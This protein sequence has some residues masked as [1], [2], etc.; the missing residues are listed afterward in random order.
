MTTKIAKKVFI[1]SLVALLI[2]AMAFT[3]CKIKKKT[4]EEMLSCALTTSKAS[5]E[6][7]NSIVETAK[8]LKDGLVTVV[9]DGGE[10][11]ASMTLYYKDGKLA[12][13]TGFL[14]EL[15][16]IDL[17]EL[18]DK[19]PKSMFG[20]EGGNLFNFKKSDEQ[21]LIDAA[22]KFT[23]AEDVDIVKEI[24]DIVKENGTM[25]AEYGSKVELRSGDT[26]ADVL[27]LSFTAEQVKKIFNDVFEKLNG[28]ASRITGDE[29][30]KLDSDIIVSGDIGDND[31][32]ANVKLYTDTKT[33]EILGGVVVIREADEENDLTVKFDVERDDNTVKYELRVPGEDEDLNAVFTVS[34]AGGS[35]QIRF[36]ADGEEVFKYEF[37]REGKFVAVSFFGHESRLNYDVERRADDSV[38]SVSASFEIP[39]E[40]LGGIVGP[41]FGSAFGGFGFG[42][43]DFGF[44]GEDFGFGGE[45][46]GEDPDFNDYEYDYDYDNGYDYVP[47]NV[48]VRM[49]CDVEGAMPEY[50]NILDMSA[51]DL[52]KM[53]MD[54]LLSGAVQE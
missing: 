45:D 1:V 37:S 14:G 22:E 48:K 9:I 15:I 36:S 51:A 47:A 20:T 3:G 25:T 32:A 11:G 52:Q 38:K 8:T 26:K 40:M 29:S 54:L 44:G 7:K 24:M 19:F 16:G 33:G 35:E 49:N 13:D 41:L 28:L 2:C 5:F 12:I 43:E 10:E 23:H 34:N 31:E 6:E 46:F 17:S 30:F 53:L 39:A 18:K 21:E 27:N 50:R 42:G 4:P